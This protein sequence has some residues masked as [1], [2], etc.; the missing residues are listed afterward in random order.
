[1]SVFCLL[2]MF[3]AQSHSASPLRARSRF[4]ALT[5][6]AHSPVTTLWWEVWLGLG[7]SR[8]REAK[9]FGIFS[10]PLTYPQFPFRSFLI[11]KRYPQQ[12]VVFK[13]GANCLSLWPFDLIVE[14][15]K[16]WHLCQTFQLRLIGSLPHVIPWCSWTMGHWWVI[17]WRKPC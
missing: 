2:Q 16:K 7:K 6:L 12:L 10:G 4:A 5:K 8:L 3:I 14:R 15:G 1:M 11:I 17:H 13:L 9:L